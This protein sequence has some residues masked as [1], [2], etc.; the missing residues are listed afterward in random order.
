[1]PPEKRKRP[2]WKAERSVYLHSG[3]TR[4]YLNPGIRAR[5][6]LQRQPPKQGVRRHDRHDPRL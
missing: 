2:A 4:F 1:M 5:A 6:C 3:L